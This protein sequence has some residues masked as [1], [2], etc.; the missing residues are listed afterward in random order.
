MCVKLGR[1]GGALIMAT[2]ALCAAAP[3]AY[4]EETKPIPTPCAG[5]ALTDAA[6]DATFTDLAAPPEFESPAPDNNDVQNVFFTWDTA[7]DGKKKLR[8][9]IQVE[10]LDKT[11]TPTAEPST[12]TWA[13]SFTVGEDDHVVWVTLTEEGW[14]YTLRAY[15]PDTGVR[16]V[17]FPEVPGEAFEGPKGVLSV[18]LPSEYVPG[19][20]AGVQITDVAIDVYPDNNPVVSMRTDWAPED[21]DP[22]GAWTVQQCAPPADPPGDDPIDDPI[23]PPIDPPVDDKDEDKKDE[24]K[25]DTAAPPAPPAPPAAQPAAA[26]PA[27]AALPV[28]PRAAL[29]AKK[30]AA[31]KK[32]SCAKTKAK[33]KSKKAKRAAA[34]CKKAAKKSKKRSK[35]S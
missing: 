5:V 2:G 25:K 26:A 1:R 11:M 29:P 18:E 14:T 15:D 30:K 27:P 32:A 28:L 12:P 8:V 20:D 34:K 19:I 31:S 23:D 9:N 33:A 17:P 7:A 13:V 6:G 4:A 21:E 10:K 3:S 16:M 22:A 24:A 35:R